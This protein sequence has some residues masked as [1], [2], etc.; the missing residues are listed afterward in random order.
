[1]PKTQKL[2]LLRLGAAHVKRIE[3]MSTVSYLPPNSFTQRS[4]RYTKQHG[5]RGLL[6]AD[7]LNLQRHD[8]R[9]ASWDPTDSQQR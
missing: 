6:Q 7:V 9:V 8:Q 2:Q 5:L 3:H 4:K 1:M